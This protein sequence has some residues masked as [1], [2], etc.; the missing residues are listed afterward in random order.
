MSTESATQ[1]NSFQ[2]YISAVRA[3]WTDVQD[4]ELPMKVKGLMEELLTT[5]ERDE[6]WMA[7]LISEAK[8]AKELYRDPDHGFIQMAHVQPQGH[9]NPPHDHG[10]CWV[11]YGAYT[12]LTEIV[13]YGR[14]GEEAQTGRTLL[15]QK[16]VHELIQGVVHPYFPGDVHSVV[17]LSGPAVV[18]RFLS[19][20]LNKVQRRYYDLEKNA[21]IVDRA[22]VSLS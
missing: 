13:L 15:E 4:P 10:P 18:F 21:V 12:G 5:T 2:R 8:F 19:Y 14:A 17:A 11:V 20:D 3:V 1:A 22:S 16:A 6:P 7:Q 9:S